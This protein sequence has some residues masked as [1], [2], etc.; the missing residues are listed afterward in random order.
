M[1]ILFFLFFFR[2]I[3][4]MQIKPVGGLCY[5]LNTGS[6]KLRCQKENDKNNNESSGLFDLFHVVE[7]LHR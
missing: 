5:P 1:F 3:F 7:F 6:G 4:C 2:N